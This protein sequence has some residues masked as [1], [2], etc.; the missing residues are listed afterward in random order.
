M[1]Q[2]TKVTVPASQP[3]GA[4]NAPASSRPK[5]PGA[6]SLFKPSMR[7]ISKNL[8]AFLWLAGLPLVITAVAEIINLSS[9]MGSHKTLAPYGFGGV[10]EL[11]G[12]LVGI[13]VGPGIIL[14]ELK[15]V[16]KKPGTA[17]A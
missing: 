8:T 9:G 10:L 12:T 4:D 6:F 17:A 11:M 5:L 14:L 1:D 16:C 13:L 3:A 7:I 2:K 15:G